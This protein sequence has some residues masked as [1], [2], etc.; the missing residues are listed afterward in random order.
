MRLGS[1]VAIVGAAAM[2]AGCGLRSDPLF[3]G[4]LID[5]TGDGSESGGESGPDPGPSACDAPIEMPPQNV[6]IEG[7]LSGADHERGWC[8]QDSG[9]EQVYNLVA[10]YNTDV[11]LQLV[12]A[13]VPLTLRIVED[14]CSDGEGRTV[15]CANDFFEQPRH[16]LAIAGHSYSIIVDSDA[17]ASGNFAF[18]VIFGWPTLD[19]CTIHEEVILQQP[20]GSFVWF[21]EFS[22]GQGTADGL[23]GGP[24]RE[25]IFPIQT[26]Y[27]GGMTAEIS[28]TN[29]M[30]PVLS[31]R[32]NC[33]GVSE[34]TCATGTVNSS[35]SLNWYF[36]APG[37]EYY[38]AVDQVGI[39]G[40]SYSL[41]VYFE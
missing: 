28:G 30:A 20:G 7:T 11:T 25:N 17:G 16:F 33:A 19:Q 9:P 27:V 40:G 3:E 22:K 10:P 29:G 23:C 24:G 1:G 21:N 8:G 13:D 26:T 31:L 6:T 37:S 14:G 4:D 39:D 38:L 35:T 32:T 15:T 41:A 34:L 2:L 12:S 5:E 18:N 36:D